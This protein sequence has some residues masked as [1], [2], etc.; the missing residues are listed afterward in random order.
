MLISG[1]IKGLSHQTRNFP[2]KTKVPGESSAKILVLNAAFG[3]FIIPSL[4]S[5]NPKIQG[6]FK[7]TMDGS[8]ANQTGGVVGKLSV[9]FP[10]KNHCF[11]IK[12]IGER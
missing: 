8:E 1:G 3:I 4:G 9:K 12:S 6:S 7:K 10:I 5:V 2:G 11:I